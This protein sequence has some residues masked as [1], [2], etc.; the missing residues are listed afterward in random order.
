MHEVITH[1]ALTHDVTAHDVTTND[2][3]IHNVITHDVTIL[4]V[5]THDA[6]THDVTIHDVTIHDVTTLS[7]DESRYLESCLQAEFLLQS[8]GGIEYDVILP[9]PSYDHESHGKSFTE[10]CVDADARMSRSV[11]RN[12]VGSVTEMRG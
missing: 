7:R 11:V 10:A 9:V 4:D 2:V 3:T 1:D 6:T 5:T 12:S 8:V